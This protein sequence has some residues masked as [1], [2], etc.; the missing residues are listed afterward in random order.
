[1]QTK[2]SRW[3]SRAAWAA[4]LGL[5]GVILGNYGLYDSLGITNQTWQILVDGL[6][7]VLVAIGV[8]NNPTDPNNF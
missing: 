4:L 3:S 8:L 6:L 2:Q 7:G 1:M 5:L